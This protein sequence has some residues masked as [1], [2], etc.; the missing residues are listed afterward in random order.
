MSRS[1]W[2]RE[3]GAYAQLAA[4]LI[5][6]L[7]AR[8]P[9]AAAALLAA[10]ASLAFLAHEPLLVVLGH[11]G[12]RM[13]EQ[14][15][16]RARGW[17]IAGGA[18][19]AASGAAGLLLAPRAAVL[20]AAIV[21]LP[22]LVLLVL[23]WRRREHTFAGELVAAAALTGAA[24]PV[25]CA[26]GVPIAAA[27]LLWLAWAL[28]FGASVVAVHRVIA[29]H[30][31]PPARIDRISAAGLGLVTA[32]AIAA[33]AVRPA[34]AVAVPLATI[35]TVVVVRPPPATRLR[36]IGVVLTVAALASSAVAVLAI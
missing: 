14:A 35:A 15:G 12:K 20:A 30:R 36:A 33:I 16:A 10:A 28:G 18:A 1:L 17:L 24:M 8:P 3:H 13:R 31:R 9:T 11:R 25:A 22:V 4:P 19:A 34:L 29:R 7:A 5:A 32:A 23:A 26:S 21:A 2:P 27:A 6:T